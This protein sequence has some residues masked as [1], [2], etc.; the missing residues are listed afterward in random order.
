VWS[1]S[2]EEGEQKP[3]KKACHNPQRG[4]KRR[5]ERKELNYWD[6]IANWKVVRG[7]AKGHPKGDNPRVSSYDAVASHLIVLRIHT[8]L[9]ED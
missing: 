5:E 8:K 9:F 6:T 1:V 3:G 7:G 2:R 4:K